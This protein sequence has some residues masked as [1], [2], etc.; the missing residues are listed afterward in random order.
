[1]L[2]SSTA[3]HTSDRQAVGKLGA[4]LVGL[5][6]RAASIWSGSRIGH[7][8]GKHQVGERFHA[9]W[10]GYEFVPRAAEPAAE[11]PKSR[12]EPT[13]QPTTSGWP[14]PRLE[15]VQTLFGEGMIAPAEAGTLVKMI[16][17]LGLNEKMT[18][19]ELGSGLGGLAR[20][21][22]TETGAYVTGFE[23]DAILAK[24]G[25]D[26]STKHG[27]SRKA[28][29]KQA[30]VTVIDVRPK[31]VDAI[32]AKEAMFTVVDKPTLFGAIRKALK[33]GGQLMLS[34]FMLAGEAPGAA[35]EA[36]GAKEPQPPHMLSVPAMR[37]ALEELGLQV[38][39][40]EDVTAEY[41]SAAIS[42]FANLAE[43][44]TSGEIGERMCPWAICEGELWSRRLAVLAS[45]EVKLIRLYARLPA[46]KELT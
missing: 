45:G 34:D 5:R 11:T 17:P 18:V 23:P 19:I 33:P 14:A 41:R 38:S 24:M 8:C 28:A 21:V 1:M 15:V 31:S 10:E 30:E 13:L 27:L 3:D 35:V 12:A 37:T 25:M 2:D 40:T 26:I 42:A 6:E 43:R 22:A 32:L 4:R 7:W 44:M 39:I 46:V 16:K 9:W 20:V 36:W 29:I